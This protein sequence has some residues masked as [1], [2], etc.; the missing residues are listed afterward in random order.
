MGSARELVRE[1]EVKT[2]VRSY[3]IGQALR[4]REVILL[5]SIYFLS[6]TGLLASRSGFPP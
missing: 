1:R 3:T 5:A 4:Q 2:A 6:V